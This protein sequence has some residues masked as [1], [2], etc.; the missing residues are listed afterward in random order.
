MHVEIGTEVAQ[1]LFLEYLFQIFGIVSL[2]F[3]VCLFNTEATEQET[4][5]MDNVRELNTM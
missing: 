1:F 5:I 3:G 2:P 4:L